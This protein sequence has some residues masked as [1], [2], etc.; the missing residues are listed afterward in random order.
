MALENLENQIGLLDKTLT[1]IMKEIKETIAELMAQHTE[2]DGETPVTPRSGT[3]TSPLKPTNKMTLEELMDVKVV[4]PFSRTNLLP[5]AHLIDTDIT[6]RFSRRQLDCHLEFQQAHLDF[7]YNL[8]NDY[9]QEP[10]QWQPIYTLDTKLIRA[11]LQLKVEHAYKAVQ[12]SMDPFKTFTPG[13]TSQYIAMK[14]LIPKRTSTPYPP[15]QDPANI[16][17]QAQIACAMLYTR[18]SDLL[19]IA[20][21]DANEVNLTAA[22]TPNAINPGITL[23]SLPT[24]SATSTLPEPTTD[25]NCQ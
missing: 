1:G 5:A 25:G 22:V 21:C 10:S 24:T 13:L 2:R 9:A 7:L 4:L 3:A 23:T 17:L 19:N 18:M 11:S 12:F 8:V 15:R 6:N 14:H 16:K 20:I